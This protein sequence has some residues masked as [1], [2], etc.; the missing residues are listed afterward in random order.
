MSLPSYVEQ[1]GHETPPKVW[2]NLL[3][4]GDP[5]SY[6]LAL[7]KRIC[8]LPWWRLNPMLLQVLTFDLP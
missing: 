6:K 1:N 5:V 3:P 7:A 2:S 4:R 8:H